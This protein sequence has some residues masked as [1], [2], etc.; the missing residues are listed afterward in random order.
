MRRYAPIDAFVA[1]SAMQIHDL[2][3]KAH[4]ARQ[5]GARFRKRKRPH[6]AALRQNEAGESALTRF[7][8]RIALADHEHLA[9]TTHDLAIAVAGL[10]G[11]ER[12]QDFHG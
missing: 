11:F 3:D 12:G 1:D 6:T 7:E 8:T 2:D 9:A 10:G 5:H 4:Q